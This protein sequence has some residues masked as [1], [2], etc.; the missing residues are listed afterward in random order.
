MFLNKT[1][2]KKTI[3]H[4]FRWEGLTVGRIC[5]GFV[6]AGG[7]WVTWTED[8]YIPNWLKAAV[9]EFTGEL[10]QQE[11]VFRAKKDEP[12]Q[13][14]IADDTIYD[15]PSL[16]Q[17]SRFAY[18]V[19]PVVVKGKFGETR[20]LQQNSTL[21][22]LGIQ[23]KFYEMID[24]GELGEENAPA[25]PSSMNAEGSIMIYKNEHSA[26]AFYPVDGTTDVVRKVMGQIGMIDFNEEDY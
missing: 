5:G 17:R 6:V 4:S 8:G 19:T 25:G 2:L 13:Y 15:L 12:I 1:L 9:M 21:N 26:Y 10:P 14:E 24:L 20:I 22:P 7:T 3:K 16:F 18:A 11:R 23:E